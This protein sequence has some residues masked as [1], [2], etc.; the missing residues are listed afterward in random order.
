MLLNKNL[1]G[2]A[3]SMTLHDITRDQIISLIRE[4]LSESN[5][6]I[7]AL[8]EL[9]IYAPLTVSEIIN[10]NI[11]DVSFIYNCL[12][13]ASAGGRIKIITFSPECRKAMED[14]LSDIPYAENAPL[15]FKEFG[16]RLSSKELS[17]LI[18]Y[19]QSLYNPK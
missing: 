15:F 5:L 10:L 9:T 14:Y 7:K 3:I 2:G 17:M 11:S 6:M 16:K 4:N 1:Q 12:L 8:F 18:K 19:F 13:I